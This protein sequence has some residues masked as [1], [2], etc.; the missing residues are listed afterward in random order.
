VIGALLLASTELTAALVAVGAT[1]ATLAV[2]L[3]ASRISKR[4]KA[5]TEERTAD[6]LRDLES[7]MEQMG[8]ELSAA[9]ERAREETTRGR[10]LGDLA[11]S[12]DLDD[13]MR[14]TL[15]AAGA[16]PGADG[17]LINV[18]NGETGPVTAS[19]GLNAEEIEEHA[20]GRSPR[21]RRIRAMLITFERGPEPLPGDTPPISVGLA[22]PIHTNSQL[23]P[24]GLLSVF[25]RGEPTIFSENQ[26]RELEELAA[27]AAPVINNAR[28]FREAR[29]L[30][31]LDALT[32]LHNRRYFYET[33]AR[34]VARAQRYNRRLGLLVFDLDDFKAINDRVGHLP[35]DAVLTDVAQRIRG[36]VRTADIACRVGGDE[37]AVILPE[38][39]LEE[40][41]QLY[42]RLQAELAAR[43]VVHAGR[44]LI[45]AGVAEL[46][47]QDDTV[48]FFQRADEALYRAKGGGKGRAAQ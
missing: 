5:G 8:L 18:E 28:R 13:V 25:S 11:G 46:R 12:L 48:T 33:L 45:S 19:V 36:V 37:F 6:L 4:T 21:A 30:A 15:E 17:A 41:D 27:Q 23:E 7:R 47:A 44:L 3:L 22:V 32:G 42:R 26:L 34:E 14:R 9:L 10:F 40:A 39:G 20:L 2:M 35:G 43:P 1:A 29:Q 16:I 31:D 24:V 38:S